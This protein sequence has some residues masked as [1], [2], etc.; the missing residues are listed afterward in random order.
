MSERGKN[1]G[2]NFNDLFH[3]LKLVLRVENKMYVIEQPIL[4]ALAAGSTDQ[5]FVDWN[6]IYDAYNEVACLILRSMTLELHRHFENSSLY[7][8]LQELKS[9]FENQARVDRFDIIQTFHAYTQEEGKPVGSYVI[10]MKGYVEQPERL[11]YVLPQDLSTI[12]ELHGLLIEYE[13]CLPKTAAT[14]QVM[15]IHIGRIQKSNKKSQKAKGKG[16]GNG[17][18]NDKPVYILNPKNPKPS[19][20]E[21]PTKDDAC[22]HCKEMGHW[23]R[24]CHAYL[25]ELITK[26]K[27]VGTASSLALVKRDTPDKRQQKSVKC[28]FIG[29]EKKRMGYYFYFPPENKIV[30]ARYAEFLEKNLI[31]QEVSGRAVELEEIQ[32]EDTSPSENTSEIPMDIEGFEP[33]QEEVIP[34]RRSVRTDRAPKRLCLN[35][36]VEEHSLRDFNEPTNYKAAMLDLE[37]NKWH[38]A[39]NANMKSMKDNQVWCLVDLPPNEKYESFKYPFMILSK[40]QEAEIKDLMRTSKSLDFAQNLDEPCVYQKASE[41]NVTFLILYV[42]DII[43]MGNHIP[44]LQSVKTYLGKCFAMKYLREAAFILGIKIYQDRTK[45][46]IGLS[47]SACMDKILKRYRMDNSKRDN[48]LMQERL[49]LNKTQGASTP[50]DVKR[51]QNVSYAS[52]IRSIMYAVRCI[53]LDVA[54]AQSITSHLQHNPAE[55][56]VDCYYDAGFETDRDDIKSQTGHRSKVTVIEESKDLTSLSLDELIGNLKVYEAKKKSSDEDSSTSDSKD[57]EYAMAV[58]DFKKFF[59]RRGRFVRQPHDERKSSQ[60]NKDDMNGKGERKCFKCGDSNH[61]IGECPKL[62]RNYNQRA[63]IEGTWSDIDEDGV[64]KT[65]DEKCLM[66]KASNEKLPTFKAFSLEDVEASTSLAKTFLTDKANLGSYTK[67]GLKDKAHVIPYCRFMKLIICHLGR[68]HN[69]HQR[70]TSL[71][72]LAK[73]D[74]RLGNLKFIPKDEKDEVFRMPIPNELISNNTRNT[75]NDSAYLEIVAKHNRRIA[76]DK[77]G[78]KKPTTAKQPK[79]KHANEKSSKLAPVPKPKSQV[80]GGGVTIQEPVAEA[81]RPLPVVKGKGKEIATEEQTAQSLLALHTLKRR[82]IID[83]FILQRWSLATE[84]G[85]TRPSTQPQDDTLANIFHESPS[86]TDAETCADSDKTTSGGDTEILQID[87]DQVVKEAVHIALQAPLSDLFRELPKAD[88]KEIVHQWMFESD[89][90]VPPNDLPEPKNNW[91]N[92]LANSF[93]DPTKS[94]LLRKT[95]DM[96]SFITWFC[97]RIGK[98]KLSKSDLEGPTFKV[99]KAFHKNNI[100]LQFQMEECHRM[101]TDQVDLVIPKAH[102][103]VPDVS[104][105]LPLGGPPGQVTIQSQYFFNKDLEYLVLGDKVRQTALSISKLKMAHYLDFGLKELVSSL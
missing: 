42:D 64:E 50:E 28:I 88:M 58:R 46:L 81:T 5:A 13:K 78:N 32:D 10:N 51:M 101:L 53:R 62:S 86:H 48:I 23:K 65:K 60:T 76:A 73:E 16:K 67:K 11:G 15:T 20:K 68:I 93:K 104:K 44:M 92:A 71:F 63:F 30:V 100:S 69:I 12:G 83:Q 59:K 55:L 14:P 25:A 80:H 35:V 7:E 99:A 84:E 56:R 2:S 77:E 52:T 8:M 82:S 90:S 26:K 19:V 96:G 1:S 22:H 66:A 95:S 38:D 33:P 74:L 31:S 37:S 41:S 39:M 97:N 24:N 57:E 98:K 54:F 3:S 27:Q 43:I 34:V 75:S 17:K 87:E 89:W 61:L 21:H 105:P 9:M 103:L 45:R 29:Y 49:N 102:Q 94:K 40:H 72:H 4:S 70:S 18:G 91:A 85:S 47:Q 6:A 79:L 36:E